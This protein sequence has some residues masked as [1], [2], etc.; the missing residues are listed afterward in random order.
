MLERRG[1]KSCRWFAFVM[2]WRRVWIL[3]KDGV[4]GVEVAF[5]VWTF[6][7]QAFATS[8]ATGRA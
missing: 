8:I 1:K 5:W 7:D 3:A 6:A 2:E 4:Y